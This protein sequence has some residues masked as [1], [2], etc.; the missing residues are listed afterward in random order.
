MKRYL[1]KQMKA[2]RRPAHVLAEKEIE[3]DVEEFE[4]KFKKSNQWIGKWRSAK[5]YSRL[6]CWLY[7]LLNKA[8]PAPVIY[9]RFDGKEIREARFMDGRH[10]YAVLRDGGVKKIRVW[11]RI[12][13]ASAALKNGIA[14]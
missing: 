11:C 8:I 14:T 13:D 9:F 10:R 6:K 7:M 3:I 5:R 1:D 12:G 4:E 2:M